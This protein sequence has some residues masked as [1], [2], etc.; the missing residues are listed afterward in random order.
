MQHFFKVSFLLLLLFTSDFL[1]F[2]QEIKEIDILINKSN[3]NSIGEK[4]DLQIN[5]RAYEIY[6]MDINSLEKQLSG[7]MKTTDTDSGFIAQISL[8]HFDGNTYLYNVK[9]NTTMSSGL[10]KKFPKIRSYDAYGVNIPSKAKIDI[11]HKGFHA[12][13]MT[14]G[15]NTIYI[16]PAIKGLNSHYMVYDRKDFISENEKTCYVNSDQ[17]NDKRDKDFFNAKDYL[18][19]EMRIYRFAVA[20]T[21]EY[22]NF[23]GGNISDAIAAQVTTMNR[24]NG[25]YERDLGV[26][27]SI[28]PDNNLIIYEGDL[29][30]DPY[31]NGDA[32]SML[33]E[34]QTN[35][36]AEIGSANYDIGHVFGTNSGG[37][38]GLGVICVNNQKAKGV[39]GSN[40]PVND[41]FD[42]DYVAHE[43]GHQFGA[44]HTQN[45]SCQRNTATAMEPG[46]A[47]TILGYAGICPPNVQNNSDDHFHGVSLQ[48]M[49]N[50]ISTTSCA[51]ESPIANS[52][53]I[54]ESTNA[55]TYIPANTPF[56]LTAFASD[57]DGDV[58]SYCWEQMDNQISTQPPE[59]SSSG[60]PN[61]RSYSP[62]NI[63]TRYFPSLENLVSSSPFA[64]N[65]EVIPSVSRTMIF[66]VS[67]RD[68]PL[69]VTGCTDY[70]DVTV[71]TVEDA[72]PFVVL[73][74][75]EE[76][77]VWGGFE[78][79][80]VT[81]DVAN[82]NEA[83]INCDTVD[84][85]LSVDGGLTYPITLA[86]NVPNNGSAEI[87]VPNIPTTTARV[88]VMCADG[89]FFDIS[90]NNFEIVELNNDF[91]LDVSPKVI[92]V[93]TPESAA[94]L[95]GIDSLD[96]FND[97][98]NLSINGL[99][100]GALATFS[101]ETVIPADSTILSISKTDAVS[102]GS[103]ILT[104]EAISSTGT[105]T[106]EIELIVR[107]GTPPNVVQ[108]SSAEGSGNDSLIWKAST[109]VDVFYEVQIATDDQFTNI[110][111][112]ASGLTA[113]SYSSNELSPSSTYFWRIRAVTVC[114]KSQ[115]TAPY[116]DPAKV[117]IFPNPTIGDITV[118]WVGE[119]DKIEVFD[120]VGKLVD[121]FQIGNGI[122]KDINLSKYRAGVYHI[123]IFSKE[124]RFIYEVIKL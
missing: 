11:T 17:R 44:N 70:T 93:C 26:T 35:I 23:H 28:I 46:S 15:K 122:T 7:V 53:P 119:V 20:A 104:L 106:K 100:D 116:F 89:T 13:I 58:L 39:T 94:F 32:F 30:T 16:D 49:G 72:G 112:E 86:S 79:E 113:T 102:P 4:G 19:C 82:T 117:T 50:R 34:N 120:A 3:L 63:P 109:E 110:I 48:E 69:N 38:A 88:M 64:L 40:A 74:P 118:S 101:N 52:A 78:G 57:E 77:I 105:K 2:G 1:T 103:Y 29:S 87:I 47:S 108:L 75:S 96:G 18:N 5:A 62:A 51:T 31:S 54:I 14:A 124:G 95:I 97:P 6:E 9:L 33:S 73:Y 36:D 61:F 83:P 42:V 43:V 66:R 121:R 84:I 90:D 114:G 76:D 12:M 27:L 80:T 25:I 67:V 115:W 91:V 41:P 10:Q 99:P 37:V 81:W 56:A 24:V 123:S 111:D 98:V 68:Q 22:T 60:G 59:S 85:F 65:W 8:P 71:T 55:N 92:N 107:S 45:N 21:V